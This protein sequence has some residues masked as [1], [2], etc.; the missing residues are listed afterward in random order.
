MFHKV[1]PPIYNVA[2]SIDWALAARDGRWD[3]MVRAM[4]VLKYNCILKNALS[5]AEQMKIEIDWLLNHRGE[6]WPHSLD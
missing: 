4:K 6:I 1:R 3:C 5:R 2:A